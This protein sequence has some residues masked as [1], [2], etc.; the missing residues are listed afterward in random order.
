MN[1][2]IGS[3]G[4]VIIV[5]NRL[6]V[7]LTT[8]D[9]GRWRV[10]PSTGGLVSA[11]SPVLRA[12]GGVWIGWPGLVADAYDRAVDDALAAATDTV[13]YTLTPV[14]LTAQQHDAFYLGFSNEI[15][16]PLFHDLQSR[17]NFDPAYW[18][19]YEQVNRLFAQVT[20]AA[21]QPQD[22]VWVQ[23]YHLMNVAQELRTLGST[24]RL[25]FFLHIPF[26]PVD[27]FLKLPWRTQIVRSLLAYDVLAF[28]TR[29]DRE[30]FAAC[31]QA[32][33][34]EARI[35]PTAD[36]TTM[37]VD[38]HA[39]TVADVPISIDAAA[40]AQLAAS[41]AVTAKAGRLRQ[42]F[43]D[44]Q[45][46]LGVDRLDYTKGLPQKLAAFREALT[47][48]PDLQGRITL[49]QI[50]VPS[51]IDIPQYADLKIAIEQMVGEINGQFTQPGWVPIHYIARSI[52]VPDLLA[53]YRAAD[54]ALVTPLKDGMNLVA[55][56]YVTCHSGDGVLILSEFAGAAAQLGG[57]ALLCNPYDVLGTAA[58][59]EHAGRLPSAERHARMDRLRRGV[60]AEDIFWW[61]A[62]CL[63]L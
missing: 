40:L 17:C 45:L 53:Y 33:L 21:M 34:P 62:R 2:R 46:V 16:W 59:I 37:L 58:A 47:R 54:I 50:A 38:G 49:T 48:F 32:V 4:R 30:N 22:D 26:P 31:V 18:A 42:A 63:E 51:R 20:A 10:E 9:D 6:P 43:C 3:A 12:R 36:R 28:Q 5:S 15:I 25:R 13:G 61:A 29:R 11:L 14:T 39:T 57:D 7:A 1:E 60:A 8:A 27:I 44:Q 23:D 41:D 52:P 19:V 55:K 35:D 24:A 56:E